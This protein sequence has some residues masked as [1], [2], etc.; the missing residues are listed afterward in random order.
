[1][2]TTE[3]F[4]LLFH[5][6][7]RWIILFSFGIAFIKSIISFITKD[8]I[9]ASIVIENKISMILMDVQL[10]IGLSLYLFFSSTTKAAFLDWKLAMQTKEL[11]FFAVEHI[12]IM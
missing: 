9:T 4:I 3:R 7:I 2:E 8:R 12:T 10:L 1:M 11:R 5:S 6:T